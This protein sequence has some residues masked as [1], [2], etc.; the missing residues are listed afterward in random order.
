MT[1]YYRAHFKIINS[2][3]ASFIFVVIGYNLLFFTVAITWRLFAL[4]CLPSHPL[5][6]LSFNTVRILLLTLQS[7][8]SRIVCLL[9]FK[10]NQDRWFIP[11]CLQE[12]S[13]YQKLWDSLDYGEKVDKSDTNY[14]Q[15]FDWSH[16]LEAVIIIWIPA[17]SVRY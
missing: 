10:V 9:M 6:K 12:F 13:L 1:F 15:L 7:S 3:N 14:G 16:D 5:A 11:S 8:K 4:K 2:G 17:Y